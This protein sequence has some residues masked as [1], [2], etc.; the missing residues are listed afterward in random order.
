MISVFA[1]WILAAVYFPDVLT[2]TYDPALQDPTVCLEQ[3]NDPSK[4]PIERM[5]PKLKDR[6][7]RPLFI[8][9]YDNEKFQKEFVQF[10]KIVNDI[11]PN[12]KWWIIRVSTGTNDIGVGG[13]GPYTL[14]GCLADFY[15]L[16]TGGKTI[17]AGCIND[18]A[19]KTLT[20]IAYD[21]FIHD[22]Q[23]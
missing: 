3:V 2:S 11:G 19:R 7:M 17:L 15:E 9:C 21:S 16:H 1:A 23:K 20:D 6:V 18:S 5:D 14:E 12:N 22:Q 10:E 4:W 13:Q 8:G